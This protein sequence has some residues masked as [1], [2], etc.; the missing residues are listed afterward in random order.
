MH[1][2]DHTLRIL[3]GQDR[4]R[5]PRLRLPTSMDPP[6]RA[7]QLA[8]RLRVEDRRQLGRGLVPIRSKAQAVRL[9]R[10]EAALGTS[11]SLRHALTS[12]YYPII[13]IPQGVNLIPVPKTS[14]TLDCFQ[15][16]QTIRLVFILRKGRF[17]GPKS[18]HPSSRN[19]SLLLVSVVISPRNLSHAPSEHP[20]SD[21]FFSFARLSHLTRTTGLLHS[22]KSPLKATLRCLLFF[23]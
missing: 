21:F 3:D 22:P 19:V 4:N 5:A 8:Y 23:V 16:N 7:Q 15:R 11:R 9:V 1:I 14:T 2:L 18:P 13:R 20:V 17:R 6:A 10:P 12:S